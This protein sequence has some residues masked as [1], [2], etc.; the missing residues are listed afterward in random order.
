[1]RK[2]KTLFFFLTSLLCKI[3]SKIFCSNNF[4]KK[5]LLC[6]F[7]FFAG[8][9]SCTL[10]SNLH[11]SRTQVPLGGVVTY[12]CRLGF[13]LQGHSA[14]YMNV[15]CQSSGQWSSSAP[16]CSGENILLQKLNVEIISLCLLHDSTLMH[17]CRFRLCAQWRCL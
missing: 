1:M 12:S 7:S 11:S 15:T 14:D 3:R 8:V 5:L 4:V 2:R 17:F 16:I 6:S 13:N 10:P 9:A